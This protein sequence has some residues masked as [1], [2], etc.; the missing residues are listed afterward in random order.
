VADAVICRLVRWLL[1]LPGAVRTELDYA[2]A[3]MEELRSWG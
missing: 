3:V 1:E 2:Q